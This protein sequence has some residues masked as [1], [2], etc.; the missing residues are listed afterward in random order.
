MREWSG[1]EK[2]EEETVEKKLMNKRR[3]SRRW[4]LKWSNVLGRAFGGKKRD[5]ER[6]RMGNDK[7][8]II[9]KKVSVME[10]WN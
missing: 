2:E 7:R 9:T 3:K 6:I 8:E 5:G 10:K 1:G 4:E